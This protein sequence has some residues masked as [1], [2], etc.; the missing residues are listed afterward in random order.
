MQN[1]IEKLAESIM[2]SNL[3]AT[4]NL[5][6]YYNSNPLHQRAVEVIDSIGSA[7]RKRN[8]NLFFS[9]LKIAQEQFL[10]D[11]ELDDSAK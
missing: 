5:I 6:K 11:Q 3:Y 4:F 9:S 10:K 2:N 7:S 1:G 8:M